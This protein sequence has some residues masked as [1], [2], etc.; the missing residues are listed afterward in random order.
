[1]DSRALHEV[2]WRLAANYRWTWR[3][4]CRRLLMSLP[5]A[6]PGQHPLDALSGLSEAQLRQL[7]DDDIFMSEVLNEASSLTQVGGEPPL[8]AIRGR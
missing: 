8:I 7:A 5:G 3:P 6:D 1:M 2:L 4:S